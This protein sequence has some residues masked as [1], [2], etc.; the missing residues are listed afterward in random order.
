MLSSFDDFFVHQT[1]RPV[2]VPATTD[3]HAYDRFWFNGYTDDGGLYL[4]IGAARYPNLGIQDCGLTVVHDGVQHAF[5]A[6][7]RMPAD[8][9]D[10][11]VGPF[12]IEIIEPMKRLRVVLDDNDTGIGADLEWTPRTASFAEDHQVLTTE[13]INRHM[14]ST[15]FNQFGHW[16]GEIRLPHTTID[17][18]PGDVWGTKD[19]SWGVRP[20]GD[21]A[22]PGAPTPH[23]GLKFFWAPLHWDDHITHLSV[24]EDSYSHQMHWDGFILPAYDDPDDIPGVTDPAIERLRAVDHDLVFA[25]GTRRVDGGTL[26]LTRVGGETLIVGLE[27]LVTAR[28]KGMGYSH[29]EWGHGLWKGEL[30]M[31]GESWRLDEIDEMAPENLHVQTV[32]AATCGTKTGIGVLEQIVVGPYPRYGFTEFLDPAT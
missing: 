1:S 2:A 3:R 5:H 8:P 25:P 20:V 23:R 9:A 27:A 29:P 14:E 28:M 31:A 21:P 32:M 11:T 7:R 10:M 4:G 15:R 6:S 12:R 30:A 17:L 18:T 19:R 26:S 13:Q 16:T 22:P 24:F